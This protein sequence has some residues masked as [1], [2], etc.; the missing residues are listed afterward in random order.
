MMAD[1]AEGVRG[2]VVDGAIISKES[3]ATLM[4]GSL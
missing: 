4:L 3:A 1:M 2:F